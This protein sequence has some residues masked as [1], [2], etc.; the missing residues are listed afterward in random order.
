MSQKRKILLFTL[1]FVTIV[2]FSIGMI[3]LSIFWNEEPHESE[4]VDYSVSAA[5]NPGA[6]QTSVGSSYYTSVSMSIEIGYGGSST[7]YGMASKSVTMGSAVGPANGII[8]YSI[9]GSNSSGLID[10]NNLVFSIHI[11]AKNSNVTIRRVY[12]HSTQNLP[13]RQIWT[14]AT[15]PGLINTGRVRIN[16]ENNGNLGPRFFLIIIVNTRFT[17]RI[18]GSTNV[19]VDSDG[20]Y[21]SVNPSS[22]ARTGYTLNGFWSGQNKTGLQVLDANGEIYAPYTPGG[23][24][25][26]G[27]TAHTYTVKYN[28]NGGSGSLA[29]QGFTYG[30]AQNLRTN[31][32]NITR[33]GYTFLGWSTNPGATSATYTNGQS[34]SNLTATKGG[35]VNLY[36]VWQ[37]NNYTV[38]FNA[39]GGTGSLADQGFSYGI[40]QNLR[41]NNNNITR[42]GYTFLGWSTNSGATSA[43]YTN[44]QS[45]NNLTSSPNGT[46]TLYAVWRRHNYT[47]KFDSNGG[48]GNMS[49]QSFSYDVSQNLSSNTFTRVGYNFIGWST[50]P[51]AN[52]AT[53]TNGQSVSNLTA[54][55][56][57]AITLYAVWSINSYQLTVNPNGG[58]WNNTTNTSS[59]TQQYNTTRA[60]SASTRSDYQFGAW[61]LDGGGTISTFG[62]LH[63]SYTD[64]FFMD[65]T[66]GTRVYNNLSNGTVTHTY[67]SSSYASANL[68]AG[69]RILRI[70][71]TGSASPGL[72][73]FTNDIGTSANKVYYAIIYAKIPV[74]YTIN[75]ANNAFG[76]GGTKTWL[77]SQAGTGDWE[78]YIHR[79]NCGSSGSFSTVNYYYLTGTAGTSENPVVWDVAYFGTYDATGLSVTGNSDPTLTYTYND[80]NASLVALWQRETVMVTLNANGGE[81]AD[82]TIEAKHKDLINLPIPSRYGYV[83]TG[84]QVESGTASMVVSQYLGQ[85]QT[86]DG[87]DDFIAIG[88]E[89]MYTDK[90]TVSLSAYMDDW[91]EYAS[92]SMRLISCTEVGGWN[93]E[94]ISGNI[95]VAIYDY[96]YGYKHVTLDKQW[97]SL[98]SGW[99]TFTFTFDGQVAR[100][101]IDN[102]FEGKSEQFSSGTIGYNGT[103]GIFI[104]AEAGTSSTTPVSG[105]YFKG[106]IKNVIIIN[107]CVLGDLNNF[108]TSN[109]AVPQND[110]SV[111]AQWEES[112]LNHTSAFS[113]TGSQADPYIISSAENLAYLSKQVYDGNQTYTGKYFKQTSNINLS[114]YL[115]QPIGID[116]DRTGVQRQHYFSGNYD[117]NGF[118]I[119][120]VKT[121]D[122][123]SG[124][125]SNQGVFGYVQ[126]QSSSAL[127]TISNV[128]V[129]NSDIQGY[130]Y[131]GGIVGYAGPR[132][133]II[134]SHNDSSV[135]GQ[136]A[137][138][139]ILGQSNSAIIT[140]CFNI[141]S[142]NGESSVGGLVGAS[143]S[144]TIDGSHNNGLV[145]GA[146]AVGG[147]LGATASQGS[148]IAT[149]SAS[150]NWGN[151]SATSDKVGGLVGY[152]SGSGI[153]NISDCGVESATVSGNSNTGIFVGQNASANSTIENCYAIVENSLS[154]IGANSGT[155]TNC[156]WIADGDKQYVGNDFS[157]FAW[158]NSDSC[159]IPKALS[160]LGH[161][162][163]ENITS[164][165]TSSSDW[166][167]W[168]A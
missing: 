19:Y 144:V 68:P 47:V 92:E 70:T 5:V 164:Q 153:V 66:N 40:A 126:G 29:D 99:H 51:N 106:I 127:A 137:V 162:W 117:G 132:T 82:T 8:G 131:V 69:A 140:D 35:T 73:G 28:A 156:I 125:Y 139:G 120:G 93:I 7:Y 122:G 63:S 90:I 142:V 80:S 143:E 149:I 135:C 1:S 32:N 160:L 167:V 10:Y 94:N 46:V 118:T 91:S 2:L 64:P 123:V 168:A 146:S 43:T 3:F 37:R 22:Y 49:D 6:Y 158:F 87:I 84:W 157:A 41:T 136:S 61:V 108:Q 86:L 17:Y 159:P 65:N 71:N 20:S 21:T 53:Y 98:A 95:Q 31:N 148:Y 76:D 134:N 15:N 128:G 12:V 27:Y 58:T 44:G 101:Y 147:L 52:S 62:K 75:S 111:V 4:A 152:I 104:G 124:I 55:D 39:N 114:A 96:S 163:T 25:Y 121:V 116:Y 154:P 79:W 74:G 83:F 48:S 14:S 13:I 9:T 105:S 130:N 107:D 26:P 72:G 50:D 155:L 145:N 24:I 138:G 129:I 34:V 89:H 165:I 78:V 85:E 113:G 23:S 11:T 133:N 161:L 18:N 57:A 150:R 54:T 100:F 119:S 110:V 166:T 151:V 112:W 42:T 102:Q 36:A 56:G 97:A 59:F 88:R 16:R 38:K 141:G 30:T 77:T 67:F 33:T 60:I 103:N 81:V 109:F 115:W 45:V